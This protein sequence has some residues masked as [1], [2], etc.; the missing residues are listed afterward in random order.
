MERRKAIAWA[1]HAYTA[2]G[3]AAGLLALHAFLDG[4]A[5]RAFGLLAAALLIDSTDGALARRFRVAEVLPRFDGRRLDDIVD[6]CAYVFVPAVILAAGGLLPD[7]AWGWACVPALASAYGFCREDAKTADGFFT[8]FPSYWNIVVLHLWL[9]R[10]PAAVNLAV[11]LLL[12]ALVFW[13]VRYIDPFKTVPLRRLTVPLTI[14]WA[15]AGIVLIATMRRP[16]PLL[17]RASLL[18]CAYYLI[19]SFGIHFGGAGRAG[20]R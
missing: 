19:A 20:A 6:Y 4:S 5:R 7:G 8:G 2:L 14:A 15:A 12:S 16:N 11:V 1:V 18:Y 9:L 13:P 3:A 10:W 17:L